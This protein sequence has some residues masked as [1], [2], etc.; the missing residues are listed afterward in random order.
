MILELHLKDFVLLAD[1]FAEL[2]R[3]QLSQN[4]SVDQ[5]EPLRAHL[6]EVHQLLR[7]LTKMNTQKKLELQQ[8]GIQK[9][10]CAETKDLALKSLVRDLFKV[11]SVDNMQDYR[12]KYKTLGDY[13][14]EGAKP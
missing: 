10:F 8:N 2:Q 14:Q 12:Q 5:R 7:Y 4:L 1:N 3:K 6:E 11:L 9:R 13:L